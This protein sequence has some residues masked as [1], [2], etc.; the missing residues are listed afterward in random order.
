MLLMLVCSV[1]CSENGPTQT[2][3]RGSFEEKLRAGATCQELFDIRNALDPHSA[4]IPRLNE[5]LRS[6]GCYSASSSRT[7][8]QKAAQERA[9]DFTVTEYRLYRRL[10]DAPMSTS[11][12][13]VYRTLAAETGRAEDE[14]RATINRVQ[15]VLAQ[16]GW[17]STVQNEIR[18]A[19]DWKGEVR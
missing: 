19:S 7:D 11:E 9:G 2:V 16:N 12:G 17:L 10:I 1:A 4:E 18:H 14:L 13:D 6:V 15:E 3:N 8:K 5:Q